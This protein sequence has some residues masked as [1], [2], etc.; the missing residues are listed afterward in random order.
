[1]PWELAPDAEPF[2]A[3][4]QGKDVVGWVWEI[5]RDDQARYVTVEISGTA[6]ATDPHY[7]PDDTRDARQTKGRSEVLRVVHLDDPPRLISLGTRGRV[8][9]GPTGWSV[10]LVGREDDLAFL[11]EAFRSD[12]LSVIFQD[13]Q[14]WLRS[15]EFDALGD[16]AAVSERAAV[17]VRTMNGAAVIERPGYEAVQLGEPRRG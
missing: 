8:A 17:L 7:L 14:H 15:S 16:T 3:P 6:M 10:P 5:T 13:G 12:E 1:M 11:S 9:T 4:W 2:D